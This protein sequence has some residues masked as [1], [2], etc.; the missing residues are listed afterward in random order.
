LT[1]TK[2]TLEAQV[3]AYSEQIKTLQPQ[4]E[5]LTHTLAQR[6]TALQSLES[7]LAQAIAPSL[8]G[9]PYESATGLK[10]TLR[11]D[12]AFI[13]SD[14]INRQVTGRYEIENGAMTLSEAS[15]RLGTARF[16][17]TCPYSQTEN[18]F[19]LGAA[20]GCVLSDQS[21]AKEEQP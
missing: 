1:Q 4:V 16:P 10:F 13:L 3:A 18:G 12:G 21:F 6:S 8:D 17:M 19:T 2:T 9:T 20:E 11:E 15:G 14:R 5:E 7:N